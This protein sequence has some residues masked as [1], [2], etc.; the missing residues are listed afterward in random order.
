MALEAFTTTAVYANDGFSRSNRYPKV[1][2]LVLQIA[3]L[4]FSFWQLVA[5]LVVPIDIFE[6]L[7]RKKVLINFR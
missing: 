2:I 5:S 4:L 3:L 6:F 1:L 7:C